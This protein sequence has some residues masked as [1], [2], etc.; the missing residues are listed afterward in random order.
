VGLNRS[1]P[2]PGAAV[3]AGAPA[4][5][6]AKPAFASGAPRENGKADSLAEK[7]VG[8]NALAEHKQKGQIAPTEPYQFRAESQVARLPQAVVKHGLT[9]RKEVHS[10]ADTGSWLPVLLLPNG[11]GTVSLRL[12]EGATEVR[13]TGFGH[14]GTGDLGT[15]FV[16]LPR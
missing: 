1:L 10:S 9:T 7:T 6:S 11:K 16:T 12:P 14:T 15:V 3:G 13:I 4:G 2:V 8:R 5:E